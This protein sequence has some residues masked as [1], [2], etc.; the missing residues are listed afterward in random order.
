MAAIT[1]LTARR[2]RPHQVAAHDDIVDSLA[3]NDRALYVSACGTGKTITLQSVACTVAPRGTVGAFFPSLFLV[4]QT[5]REWRTQYEGRWNTPIVVCSDASVVADSEDETYVSAEEIEALGA[6]VTTDPHCLAELL[7]KRS[8]ELP[9]VVFATYHSSDKLA[10]AQA[11][12]A[13]AG[14]DVAFDLIVLDEAHRVT[15]RSALGRHVLESSSIIARKRLA[16]T[17]TPRQFHVS[18][19]GDRAD[20]GDLLDET[21]YGPVAHEYGMR[22]AIG[23][24]ILSDYRVHATIIAEE[25]LGTLAS[26]D[27]DELRLH[28]G[29]A[30][31]RRAHLQLGAGRII[32]YLRSVSRARR[33]VALAKESGLAAYVITGED[34]ADDRRAILDAAFGR[35]ARGVVANVRCL[36]EGVDIPELD[37]V[38]FVDP[39]R[40]K[41]NTIQAVGRALRSS[42]G[43]YLGHVIVPVLA[44]RGDPDSW[45]NQPGW[46]IMASVLAQLADNDTA[47]RGELSAYA[48]LRTDTNAVA[49]YP[50]HRRVLIELPNDAVLDLGDHPYVAFDRVVADLSL[51]AV[52]VLDLDWGWN[53]R[54]QD[55]LY[56]EKRHGRLPT[57]YTATTG[58]TVLASWLARQRVKAT[59]AQGAKL[60]ESVPG[61]RVTRRS[62]IAW[63]QN[64]EALVEFHETYGRMPRNNASDPTESRIAGWAR[65]Q[66]RNAD[67]SPDRLTVLQ[68]RFPD[69]EWV[70]RQKPLWDE[71]FE[72]LDVFISEHARLPRPDDGPDAFRLR[73]W[74]QQQGKSKRLSAERVQLLNERMPGWQRN[75]Y[76]PPT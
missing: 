16:A 24:G 51:R 46:D 47:I 5:L 38:M 4:G 65:V 17:A 13:A 56:F 74:Y 23:D 73:G 54:L 33:F 44:G 43:K 59:E 35:S 72:A 30:A 42:V 26:L 52:R 32:T 9:Q 8:S 49:H 48:S 76:L 14:Q 61:W 12:M 1:A 27:D 25:S 67:M 21:V 69:V 39:Q 53:S 64:L 66:R 19:D 63:M 58:E 37:G 11:L 55:V 28:L 20:D 29:V 6:I 68:S 31:L 3:T 36:T 62:G 71:R 7:T 15:P 41:V 18:A 50:E 10:A 45:M 70:P 57:R 40:D 2:L 75:R 22:Q 34:P 60:D